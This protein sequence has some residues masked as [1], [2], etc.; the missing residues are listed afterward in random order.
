ML[1][2]LVCPPTTM[3]PTNNISD[4]QKKKTINEEGSCF[5]SFVVK[6]ITSQMIFFG[7]FLDGWIIMA[8]QQ[9]ISHEVTTIKMMASLD[10]YIHQQHH[11][12]HHHLS[13]LL[14]MSEVPNFE[15]GGCV[16]NYKPWVF[17]VLKTFGRIL[18]FL[19]KDFRKFRVGWF[20]NSFDF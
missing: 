4:M 9:S 13:S 11:H 7:V 1:R 18:Q 17:K 5:H 6:T 8:D 3:K 15:L 14:E 19:I 10:S 12:H 2:V 16:T 20:S